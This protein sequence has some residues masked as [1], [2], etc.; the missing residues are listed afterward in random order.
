MICTDDKNETQRAYLSPGLVG[1]Q[2]CIVRD[3]KRSARIEKKVTKKR[4]GIEPDAG[5]ADELLVREF[6]LMI[7]VELTTRDLEIAIGSIF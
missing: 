4:R 1:F 7:R 6:L 3:V 5:V 2:R